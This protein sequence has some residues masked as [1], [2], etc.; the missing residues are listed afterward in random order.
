MS[1][2]DFVALNEAYE[3][4]TESTD[5]LSITQLAVFDQDSSIPARTL[6]NVLCVILKKQWDALNIL[7]SIIEK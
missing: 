1:D 5:I 7:K 4:L 6:D 3:G 2:N